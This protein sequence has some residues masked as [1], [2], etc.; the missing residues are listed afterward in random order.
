[1]TVVLT[2]GA[3]K[4]LPSSRKQLKGNMVRRNKGCDIH[5]HGRGAPHTH[6]AGCTFANAER[7]S[8]RRWIMIGGERCHSF[9][10]LLGSELQ[11][12]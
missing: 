4:C 12:E 3:F 2:P 10:F 5:I 8:S 6:K 9:F 11:K 1:M 7:G